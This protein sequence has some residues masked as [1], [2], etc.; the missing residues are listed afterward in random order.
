VSDGF[1]ISRFYVLDECQTQYKDDCE[2]QQCADDGDDFGQDVHTSNFLFRF[3]A[4]AADRSTLTLLRSAARNES[5][6]Y[7][8]KRHFVP[9]TSLQAISTWRGALGFNDFSVAPVRVER[10]LPEPTAIQYR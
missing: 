7:G 4:R 6:N 9:E 5:E 10:A 3:R 1:F 8:L 2:E